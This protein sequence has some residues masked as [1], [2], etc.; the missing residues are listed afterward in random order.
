MPQI[1]A[2]SGSINADEKLRGCRLVPKPG[3]LQNRIP[4]EL[5][6]SNLPT[7]TRRAPR[8]TDA[9]STAKIVGAGITGILSFVAAVFTTVVESGGFWQYFWLGVCVLFFVC[10][11]SLVIFATQDGLKVDHAQV[12][13]DTHD[14]APVA[15]S[16]PGLALDGPDVHRPSV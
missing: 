15:D 11:M 8:V 9:T 6:N 2:T 16:K 5:M 1:R 14:V 10:A 3:A 12:G 7:L 13:F 4:R